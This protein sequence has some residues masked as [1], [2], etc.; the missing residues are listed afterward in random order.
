MPGIGAGGDA[1]NYWAR[2]YFEFYEKRKMALPSRSD[3]VIVE[4][5]KHGKVV[6][7]TNSANLELMQYISNPGYEG[8]DRIVYRVLVEGQ[9]VKLI[10]FVHVTKKNLDASP[11]PK[12]CRT[13][14]W[15]ISSTGDGS[16]EL[17]DNASVDP[18]NYTISD[19]ANSG[20]PF[21]PLSSNHEGVR[22]TG[23]GGATVD[24]TD[25]MLHGGLP[26]NPLQER[27]Y[28]SKAS[29][30]DRAAAFLQ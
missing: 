28:K 2:D 4:Q 9:P 22:Y 16:W 6:K 27:F 25:G 11:S 18:G 23:L 17:Q 30:V 1:P 13:G 7:G 15:K 10:Y 8:R 26:A 24:G 21:G 5:P 20:F 29:T 12:F 19:T 14:V 3:V